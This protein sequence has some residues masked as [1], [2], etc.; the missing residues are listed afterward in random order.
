MNE[1]ELKATI[2]LQAIEYMIANL[3][4]VVYGVLGTPTETIAQLHAE[5]RDR[6]R[7]TPLVGLTPVQ[8]DLISAELD[9]AVGRLMAM[10]EE[11]M[12]MRRNPLL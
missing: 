3:Y 5:A 12:G 2:R 8:S 6:F 9:S 7:N 4:K 1:E 11:M 10:I